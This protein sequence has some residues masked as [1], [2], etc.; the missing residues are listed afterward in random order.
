MAGFY[1]LRDS[2]D[3]GKPDNPLGLPTFPYEVPIVI[4]DRIFKENGDM[5]YPASAGDPFYDDYITDESADVPVEGGP[6]QLAEFFGDVMIVNGK[7]WPKMEVEPRHYRY[8]ILNGCD[9]RYLIIQFVAVGKAGYVTDLSQAGDPIEFKVI[10]TDQGRGPEKSM[11]TLLVSPGSRVDIVCNFNGYEGKRIIMKQLG[12]DEPYKGEQGEPK[13]E[14]TTTFQYTD[15]VMAFDVVLGLYSEVL[16]GFNGY[17]YV[18]GKPDSMEFDI[19]KGF[20]PYKEVVESEP[21]YVE[22]SEGSGDDDD[23]DERELRE[24][25]SGSIRKRRLALFEGTDE[26]GRLQPLLGTVDPAADMFGQPILWP[27][28]EAFQ[29]TGLAGKPM[30]GYV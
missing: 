19:F 14:S 20:Y 12:P 6:T 5:F 9:S 21:M 13:D 10:G 28:N 30:E 24:L 8:R 23:R 22:D 17:T 4:Q 15:R 16:D 2:L 11:D 26:F 29:G 25:S 27:E 7:A 18:N 3:T 1:I